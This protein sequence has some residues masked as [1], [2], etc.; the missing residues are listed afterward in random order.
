MLKGRTA[1]RFTRGK[2]RGMRPTGKKNVMNKQESNYATHLRHLTETKQIVDYQYEPFGLRLAQHRCHYHPDFFVTFED[3]F[4]VHEVKAYSKKTGKP[5]WEDD[6]IIKFKVAANLFPY[7]RFKI[8]Y[9]NSVEQ[10][11]QYLEF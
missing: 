7:W 6:A 8:V 5:R 10:D 4:E 1:Q 3:R 11:W 9:F 2:R